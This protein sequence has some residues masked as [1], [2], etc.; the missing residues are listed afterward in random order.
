M[1]AMYWRRERKY[2]PAKQRAKLASDHASL[3]QLREEESDEF[4]TVKAELRRGVMNAMYWG[5]DRERRSELSRFDGMLR[6]A[7]GPEAGLSRKQLK[8]VN[9]ALIETGEA[10]RLSTVKPLAPE[11]R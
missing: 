9:G 3:Y 10:L 8:I 5:H 2:G 11:R 1:N 4:D 6:A 7:R